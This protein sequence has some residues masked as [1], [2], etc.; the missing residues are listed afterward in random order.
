MDWK[1]YLGPL[2]LISI[3]IIFLA[4]LLIMGG[5]N[6]FDGDDQLFMALNPPFNPA[7]PK[8]FDYFFVNYSIW[9][10][11]DFGLGIWAFIPFL[12]I[13][14]GLSLKFD[15]FKPSRLLILL[16]IVMLIKIA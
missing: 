2:I 12:A 5:G 6:L 8:I 9:G 4:V 7:D 16:V 14:G 1:K 11:G 10:P 13:L 3:S 15:T